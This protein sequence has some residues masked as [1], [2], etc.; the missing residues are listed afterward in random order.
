MTVTITESAADQ[1]KKITADTKLL[2][3]VE[4]SAGGC[5]G[6]DKK[7][8]MDTVAK[9]DDIQIQLSNGV[10]VLIDEMSYT[11]LENSKVDYKQGLA[12]SY[13][14]IDIPEAAS[15]CGCGTSFSL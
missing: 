1:F 15:T 14:Y 7:F 8:S 6:F 2:P 9:P 12:S 3:R 10:V 11:M 4:I 5:N 13:F